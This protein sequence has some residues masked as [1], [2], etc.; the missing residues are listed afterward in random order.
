MGNDSS[1][2]RLQLPS[3]AKTGMIDSTNFFVP[4]P[5]DKNNWLHQGTFVGLKRYG[6]DVVLLCPSIFN[7]KER[8][9][10]N[11]M[12]IGPS[13]TN[14][15][16][17][18]ELKDVLPEMK[19]L[20][21]QY[22]RLLFNQTTKRQILL[23]FDTV[24]HW[25]L[26]SRKDETIQPAQAK[27]AHELN[28]VRTWMQVDCSLSR[29][30]FLFESLNHHELYT[31]FTSLEIPDGNMWDMDSGKLQYISQSI[32]SPNV[33]FFVTSRSDYLGK[34]FG[35]HCQS[36]GVN[37]ARCTLFQV[38]NSRL[39]LNFDTKR[40][41]SHYNLC[42]VVDKRNMSI[43]VLLIY[44]STVRKKSSELVGDRDSYCFL[45]YPT[46]SFF[47]RSGIKLLRWDGRCLFPVKPLLSNRLAPIDFI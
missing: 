41:G 8:G 39:V 5:P 20:H 3:W 29:D 7:G 33:W 21:G 34:T 15:Q 32:Y 10:A 11:A 44:S 6:F 43:L 17:L 18:Q 23:L 19:K 22:F 4:L 42:R 24:Q 46:G 25:I 14:D 12:C 26:I 31:F 13:K 45:F 40:L 36:G 28:R 16:L 2:S 38:M 35:I 37:W 30:S 27:D 47:N 1:S 9:C